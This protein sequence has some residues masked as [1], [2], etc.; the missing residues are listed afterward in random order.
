MP[1]LIPRENVYDSDS[2]DSSVPKVD[3]KRIAKKPTVAGKNHAPAGRRRRRKHERSQKQWPRNL[4][5]CQAV[6]L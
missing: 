2:D 3:V 6:V 1:D 4:L 5:P